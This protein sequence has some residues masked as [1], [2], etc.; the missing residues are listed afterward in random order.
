MST[1][2]VP[3]PSNRQYLQ[4]PRFQD[5]SVQQ[6]VAEY[7]VFL[8]FSQIHVQTVDGELIAVTPISTA[9]RVKQR[10]IMTSGE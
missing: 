7:G 9:A 3:R 4:L 10:D 6:P 5:V 2:R 1:R 8:F